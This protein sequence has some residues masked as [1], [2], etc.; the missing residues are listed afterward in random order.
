MEI[1]FVAG[2]GPITRDASAARAF[3]EDGL[4]IASAQTGVVVMYADDTP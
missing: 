4:G 2:F 3:W 1:S